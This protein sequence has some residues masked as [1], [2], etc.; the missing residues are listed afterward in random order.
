MC[1]VKKNRRFSRLLFFLKMILDECE[2][3]VLLD[4]QIC[5]VKLDE[6]EGRLL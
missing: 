6:I 4:P 1:Q 3:R 2:T 5:L